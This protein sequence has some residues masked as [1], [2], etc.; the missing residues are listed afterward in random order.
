MIKLAFAAVLVVFAARA[1]TVGWNTP[2]ALAS[3]TKRGHQV[4][5]ASVKDGALH[6][7]CGGTDTHLYSGTFDIASSASQEVVF[8]AKGNRSGTGEIFW[9]EPG[10]GPTQKQS[11]CFEWIGDGEWHDYRVRPFWQGERRIGQLRLDFPPSGAQGGVFSVASIGVDSTAK[12]TAFSSDKWGGLVFDVKADAP[13]AGHFAWASSVRSGLRK[14]GFRH[15]GDGR[16][17]RIYLDLAADSG[18]S[19][20]ISWTNLVVD[21]AQVSSVA[22]VEGKPALAPDLV[23]KGARAE[24][25]FNRV[26]EQVPVRVSVENIGTLAAR[27]VALTADALPRGVRLA[28]A[29]GL[30]DLGELCGLETRSFTAEFEVEAPCAF[31]A[32]L[33][34]RAEGL[35][36]VPFSVPVKVLP[37]LNLPKASY[38][39]EPRPAETDYDIAALYFPGWGRVEAWRRVWNVCPERKPVLGWYDEANP[40]VVDWQIKWLVENGIRT[41]YV[42]WYWDRG[43]QHHDHWV[44]AFYKARYRRHMKWAMMWANHNPKGSH[45]EADQRAVT[46]FWIESYFNTPE[47]LRIDGKPVVWIWSAANMDRDLGPGGCRK[48]LEI[49]RQMAR[50]A[51]YEGICFIAMKWPEADWSAKAVQSCKDRGFD[52]T[53]IYHFMDHG[54]KARSGR[55]YSYDLCVDASLPAWR[56]RQATG[57]LPF[58]PNLSTGWDDRPWND[59]CEI[60]GKNADSFQR[61]CRDAKR[62]ADETG[63]KRLCLA[64]LNE[65]GEGSYAEPNAEHGFGFYE[66]VRDTF[67]KRPADGWPLNYGPKDVG[68][69]PYD[70]PPPASP[71]RA[72]PGKQD[73]AWA[74]P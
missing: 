64:P 23:V 41:L 1:G 20:A 6:V 62:F 70:L 16:V 63:V 65:W 46:K 57:I 69:G 55:R 36:P 34:L 21:A 15:P 35:E 29:A 32:R 73:T 22:F 49:S 71:A 2:E 43:R 50:A 51:G 30:A 8:R 45:S 10:K 52:M 68:L 72:K 26:G 9:M 39:P 48:L 31:T 12:V 14:K 47:Y 38:V 61:L 74:N 66:A 19:G 24:D 37:S 25:A 56:K 54:G 11:V 17:H 53:G 27:H 60:Y 33:S 58:I 3:W 4:A 7:V 42:D 18:W 59:R 44:K 28:N 40:E 5:S 67:C 13:G